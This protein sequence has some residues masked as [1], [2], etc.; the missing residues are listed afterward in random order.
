[1]TN[2]FNNFFT[3]R[4]LIMSTLTL[5]L[6]YMHIRKCISVCLFVCFWFI[7]IWSTLEKYPRGFARG[8]SWRWMLSAHVVLPK[9]SQEETRTQRE[10]VD[11]TRDQTYA[12]ALSDHIWSWPLSLTFHLILPNCKSASYTSESNQI[13]IV[14]CSM[15]T[16]W[17]Q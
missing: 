16:K 3:S 15:V 10:A 1:M 9:R 14:Q 2:S 11:G 13:I 12:S 17:P 5:Y 8:I 6:H 7:S 4:S